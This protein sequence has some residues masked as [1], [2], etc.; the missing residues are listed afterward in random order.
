MIYL[1]TTI[2]VTLAVRNNLKELMR[3]VDKGNCDGMVIVPLSITGLIP[4]THFLS[5][6]LIPQYIYN[7]LKNDI[8]LY[9]R[10]KKVWEDDG[11]VFPYT[12]L[13]ITSALTQCDIT[14]MTKTII[15]NGQNVIAFEHWSEVLARLNLKFVTTII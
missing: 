6:G 4:V 11:N 5:S 10:A 3:R 15:I 8:L 12:Q 1:P 13:Q 7:T 9:T 14:D 2:I